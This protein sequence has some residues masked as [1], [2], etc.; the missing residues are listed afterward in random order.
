M[1]SKK[2]FSQIQLLYTLRL[3]QVAASPSGC[4]ARCAT[5]RRSTF[6]SSKK[7]AA[8]VV[9]NNPTGVSNPA[10]RQTGLIDRLVNYELYWY[11]RNKKNK[12]YTKL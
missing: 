11:E 12:L 1:T 3:L 8:V 4:S 7:S 6:R 10:E 5:G 9:Y 2:P